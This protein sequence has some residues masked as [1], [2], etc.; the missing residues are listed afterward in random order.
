[1]DFKIGEIQPLIDG[2]QIPYQSLEQEA[3][4]I[5]PVEKTEQSGS[6][7]IGK[8]AQKNQQYA[9]QEKLDPE[10]GKALAAEVQSY[11]SDLNI[12][13]NFQYHSKTGQMVVQVINSS[14]NQVIRQIPPEGLVH[15]RE[16]LVEL[17]G[18]LFNDK[19]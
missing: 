13:L 7:Q 9:S 1:M 14:T 6:A 11:L 2:S 12:Q 19:T 10:T 17:R 18:A 4:L 16:Q 5:Q 3:D 8:D 15:L